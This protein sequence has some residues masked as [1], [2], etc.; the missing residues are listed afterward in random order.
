[1]TTNINKTKLNQAQQTELNL[2]DAIVEQA[3]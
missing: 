2:T 3:I 1:M